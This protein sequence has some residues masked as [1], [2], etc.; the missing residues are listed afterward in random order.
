MCLFFSWI[1]D[2]IF[3]HIHF[4][5]LELCS[6]KHLRACT[7]LQ[8]GHSPEQVIWKMRTKNT[9]YTIHMTLIIYILDVS[10]IRFSSLELVLEFRISEFRDLWIRQRRLFTKKAFYYKEGFLL[11]AVTCNFVLFLHVSTVYH[12]TYKYM[13]LAKY[14][15]LKNWITIAI[16]NKNKTINIMQTLRLTYV[17]SPCCLQ[18]CI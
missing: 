4:S 17:K 13:Q 1:P 10:G 5:I 12:F 15:L 7:M 11:L 2:E 9:I 16:C 6:E 18:H 3:W 14:L 8:L